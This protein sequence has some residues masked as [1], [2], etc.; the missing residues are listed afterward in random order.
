MLTTLFG[1]AVLIVVLY[2]GL[3]LLKLPN[4]WCG[5]VSAAVPMAAYSLLAARDWPGL[6]VVTMHIT[7]FVAA[8]VVLSLINGRRR[9][10]GEKL[11]WAPKVFIGFFA[12]LFVLLG[13]FAYI[14]TNGLPDA[15]AKRVLP[16]GASGGVHTAFAGV[17][18]HG[19]DAAKG[20][21]EHL[22][23][24][25]RQSGLG[26]HITVEGLDHLAL[27]QAKEIT[28]QVQDRAGAPLT[29]VSAQ[30]ILSRPAQRTADA[31]I[32]FRPAE[33]G[34]YRG[35]LQLTVSGQWHA[36][37]RVEHGSDAIEIEQPIVSVLTP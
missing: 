21:S 27:N 36:L 17:V 32:T 2:Y 28:L 16:G 22:K 18:P 7:V 34:L 5:V 33:A 4:Y 19:E 9:V 31:I 26:W 14:A 6:D 24:R 35:T 37:L 13:V 10:Q 25:D 30:L 12:A 23:Q 11:H 8:A 3:R 20:I 29:D 1:G 15:I